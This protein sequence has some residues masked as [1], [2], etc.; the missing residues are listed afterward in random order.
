MQISKKLQ[1]ILLSSLTVG[2]ITFMP[3]IYNFD[4][5]HLPIIVSI[6]HAEVKTYVGIDTAMCDFGEDDPEMVKM[7]QV[8]AQSRAFQAAKEKAGVYIKSYTQS[9]NAVVTEDSVSTMTNVIVDVLEIKYKKMPYSAHKANGESFGKIG[10][11]YEAT[12]TVKID[13][14]GIINYLKTDSKLR[15]TLESQNKGF[16][17]SFIRIDKEL[18]NI[19][20]DSI[21]AKTV[22]EKNKV[23]ADLDKTYKNILAN[24]KLA[25]G[26]KLAHKKDYQGSIFKYSEAIKL[27][28]DYV[29]AYNNR[30]VS[31]YDLENY[32]DAI[33][34]YNKVIQLNPNYATAY[35]N[36]GL[37]YED[38]GDYK[39]ALADYS[40]A[41]QLDPNDAIFYN[42]CGNAY[43]KLQNYKLSIIKYNKAIQLDPN[44]E[45]AYYNRGLSYIYLQNY[46]EAIT[47]YDKVI[48]L[49]PNYIEAYDRRGLVYALLK[50]YKQAIANWSEA[51]QLNPNIAEFYVA[52]GYAYKALG[53]NAK[54]QSDFS[55]AISLGFKL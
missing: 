48:Q 14:N 50:N 7:I 46:K 44:Y 13:T 24:Q 10:F 11:M 17:D 5:T 39:Q 20:K 54:A 26:N 47:D 33:A 49:N 25:E 2:V 31:Y 8:A 53:D 38:I 45:L 34:D 27:D 37:I 19:Q 55:K 42:N 4:D 15:A 18:D 30:G 21:N 32:K 40:R 23:K 9:I 22:A 43:S 3:V 35:N 1:N 28:P 41:I 51:I 12:V 36:R 6:A 16:E 52:R 29:E